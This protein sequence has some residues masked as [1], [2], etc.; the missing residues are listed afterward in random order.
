MINQTFQR[1]NPPD[2]EPKSNR[3]VS[4]AELPRLRNSPAEPAALANRPSRPFERSP[5]GSAR[6]ARS[7]LR[8]KENSD[9]QIHSRRRGDDR[10]GGNR[11]PGHR[12][13]AEPTA[14]AH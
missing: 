6:H 8:R 1:I 4:Y 5:V 10:G 13:V 7:H 2:G 14:T 12:L 9:E 3:C 11:P